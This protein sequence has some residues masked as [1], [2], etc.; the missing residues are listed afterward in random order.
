V[1]INDV[2]V[3]LTERNNHVNQVNPVALAEKEWTDEY[4]L[5]K[6]IK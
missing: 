3:C 2:S 1:H 6:L 4:K 5:A